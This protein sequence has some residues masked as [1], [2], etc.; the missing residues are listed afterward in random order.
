MATQIQIA[1]TSTFAF[2]VKKY[3]K[4]TFTITVKTGKKKAKNYK[5]N[6]TSAKCVDV[7]HN[8]KSGQL[9]DGTTE[10]RHRPVKIDFVQSMTPYPSETPKPKP[11]NGKNLKAGKAYYNVPKKG[12][13][14]YLKP[15]KNGLKTKGRK[16]R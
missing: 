12:T 16:K 3:G 7:G 4:T 9:G 2:I 6:F 10:D 8:S 15:T 13:A 14:Q 1:Q 11:V 5:C